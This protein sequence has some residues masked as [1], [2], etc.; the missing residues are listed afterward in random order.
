LTAIESSSPV[1]PEFVAS[2][3]STVRSRRMFMSPNLEL[4]E[5]PDTWSHS[6]H[7]YGLLWL[8]G[9]R[10]NADCNFWVTNYLRENLLRDLSPFIATRKISTRPGRDS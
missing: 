9:D 1:A 3:D 5:R 10:H 4:I 8:R 6:Y 2:R 7:Y